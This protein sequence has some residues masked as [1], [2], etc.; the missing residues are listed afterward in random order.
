MQ[1]SNTTAS[2]SAA[3]FRR[4]MTCIS[5]E[6]KEVSATNVAAYCYVN[7]RVGAGAGHVVLRLGQ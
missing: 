1:P 2:A 5:G 6:V 3:R 4:G 7:Y